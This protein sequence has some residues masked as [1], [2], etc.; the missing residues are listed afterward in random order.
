M[1][2]QKEGERGHAD[3]RYGLVLGAGGILGG[4]WTIGAM[5]A[6]EDI[7]GRD[8][9]SAEL[10]VGT[11]VGS[12]LST[13]VV[14]GV[15]TSEL[16]ANEY[17]AL[18]EGPLAHNELGP[19]ATFEAR[20][21]WTHRGVGSPELLARSLA[22]PLGSTLLAWGAALCPPGQG[23]LDSVRRVIERVA[24]NGAWPGRLRIVATDY[25]SGHREVFQESTANP[26]SVADAVV[27]SCSLPGYFPAASIN[28]RRYVDGAVR[29]S[30]NADVLLGAEL[31]EVY[32]LA[33]LAARSF[34]TPQTAFGW[35][36]RTL[37]IGFNRTLRAETR[38]LSE[39]GTRVTVLAPNADDLNAMGANM[40]TVDRR[41]EVLETARRNVLGW[42]DE[43]ATS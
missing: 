18:T 24:G 30:T 14:E 34:D 31:D 15:G 8:V 17:G 4:C 10:V 33:P 23:S 12:L 42:F 36:E 3:R 21:R 22:N 27:A 25:A 40:M 13:L 1:R 2:P 19:D 6:L 7:T 32:V 43:A 9:R 35:L 28:G 38:A 39:V 20:P 37:R 41:V 16:A 11:S 5:Q 29:S 26:V